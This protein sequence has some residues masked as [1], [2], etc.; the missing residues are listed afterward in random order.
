MP[1]WRIQELYLISCV[2]PV[3]I[4]KHHF[5]RKYYSSA[6]I[7]IY[8]PEKIAVYTAYSYVPE[9]LF[10]CWFA[11]TFQQLSAVV[12]EVSWDPEEAQ[13]VCCD[14]GCSCCETCSSLEATS[15]SLSPG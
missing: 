13:R 8:M 15:V 11:P 1:V 12:V 2:S 9:E 10:H 7:G 4:K 5:T 14:G 3:N 6:Y